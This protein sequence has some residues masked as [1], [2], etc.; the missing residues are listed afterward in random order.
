[1]NFYRNL[2]QCE[3]WENSLTQNSP[4]L[5]DVRVTC[6][7]SCAYCTAQ[8]IYVSKSCQVK[9]LAYRYDVNKSGGSLYSPSHT[10]SETHFFS[11]ANVSTNNVYPFPALKQSATDEI[12]GFPGKPYFMSYK[13]NVSLYPFSLFFSPHNAN[14]LKECW[15]VLLVTIWAFYWTQTDFGWFSG[16]FPFQQSVNTTQTVFRWN[17]CSFNPGWRLVNGLINQADW[18]RFSIYPT[19]NG[20]F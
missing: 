1:M 5:K 13:S 10:L 19:K 15:L 4:D 6:R 20:W 7:C 2:P 8:A 3:F 11:F 14:F 17:G 16:Y 9:H 18:N 12:N